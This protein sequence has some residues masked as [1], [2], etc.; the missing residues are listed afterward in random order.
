MKRTDLSEALDNAYKHNEL[1]QI[2]FKVDIHQNK[3]I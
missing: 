1:P 3:V 2:I